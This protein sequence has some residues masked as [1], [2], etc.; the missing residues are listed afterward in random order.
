LCLLP[1]FSVV[2]ITAC[3]V[4]SVVTGLVL[5]SLIGRR[6]ARPRKRRYADIDYL[7][8]AFIVITIFK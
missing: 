3:L 5:G 1:D 8:F 6:E 2:I 4:D 7:S